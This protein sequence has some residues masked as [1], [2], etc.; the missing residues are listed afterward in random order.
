MT[1]PLK[2]GA[3]ITPFHAVDQNPTLALHRDLE[4]AVRADELGYDEVWFGEHHS[5]GMETIPSP[6]LM[7]AAAGERT[8]HVR[9]GTGV[10][11]LP[12][13]HPLMLA[14]RMTQLDHMTRGRVMFGIGPGALP[15]DSHMMGLDPVENRRK[16]E[17]SIEAI[18]ALL[19]SD[20]PVSRETDWF[21]LKDARLNLSPYQHPCFEIAAAAQLSPSGPT[22]AGT[23]GL[24]LMSLGATSAGGFDQLS[25]HWNTLVE[26]ASQAGRKEPDRGTW[27][28]IGPMHVA[29]TEKQA[30]EDVKF[31]ILKWINYFRNVAALPVGVDEDDTDIIVDAM[32]ESGFAVIGTPAMA[33]A[34]IQRL[35]D[36][37]GGFGTYLF[38]GHEW[39][40][41]AATMKSYELFARDV[42]PQFQFTTR[43]ARNSYDWVANNR[44]LFVKQQRDAW[45]K[46]GGAL[47]L[48]R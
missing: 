10:S 12:Y 17:E 21:T 9:L 42:I 27:R 14:D 8:K 3:F 39:A 33:A 37:S 16:A 23:H 43:R 15:S 22:L 29:E 4:L 48:D 32:N 31:G 35:W 38:F 46:A 30:R 34:Q 6:E 1:W 47:G 40:D 28:L 11:S 45:K 44:E 24:S 19:T 5:G 13:H 41:R 25:A 36:Q 7:I 20:E 26:A 18:I 2:F